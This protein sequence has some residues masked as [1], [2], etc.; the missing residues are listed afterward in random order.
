MRNF[1]YALL[2][3]AALLLSSCSLPGA[4][5]RHH[6]TPAEAVA[7]IVAEHPEL[8]AKP[9]TIK[10]KVYYKVPE[11]HFEK[12]LVPVY[13]TVYIQRDANRLDTLV[14]QLQSRLDSAHLVAVRAQLHKLLMQR[15]VLTDTLRFDTLGVAG[16]VWRTGRSYRV[17]LVR[18][19]IQDTARTQLLQPRLR[20]LPPAPVAIYN[21][22]GW[23]LDWWHWLL[24]G[25]LLGALAM[26][27][28]ARIFLSILTR[29]ADA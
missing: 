21:P 7:K 20:V 23:G 8:V 12:E 16:K 11:I 9:E 14:N 29:R 28:V 6:D 18:A 1:K 3:S 22:A 25:L 13:D 27:L 2:A 17:H 26:C 4:L 5:R 24:I 10:V 19:A 15:P